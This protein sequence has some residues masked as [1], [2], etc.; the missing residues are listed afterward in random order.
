[1]SV[2]RPDFCSGGRSVCSG[3]IMRKQGNRYTFGYLGRWADL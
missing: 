1:M 2:M 3:R